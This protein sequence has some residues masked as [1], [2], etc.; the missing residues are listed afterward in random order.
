MNKEL[1]AIITL[2]G[3]ALG[4]RTQGLHKQ[5]DALDAIARGIEAKRNVDQHM[6]EV[7]DMLNSTDGISEDQW[8]EQSRRI[9]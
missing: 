4:L 6:Q 9:D 2:R 1:L 8:N 5:A 3:T 7:A